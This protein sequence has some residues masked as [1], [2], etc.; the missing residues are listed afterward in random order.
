M[1]VPCIF[2]KKYLKFDYVVILDFIQFHWLF[3]NLSHALFWYHDL[4]LAKFGTPTVRHHFGENTND[5]EKNNYASC[6]SIV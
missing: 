2:P 3:F 6:L 4:K 5:R 1:T